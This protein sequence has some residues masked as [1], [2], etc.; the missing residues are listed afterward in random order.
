MP[1]KREINLADFGVNGVEKRGRSRGENSS[2]TLTIWSVGGIVLA[3]CGTEDHGANLFG[4][5]PES[6]IPGAD[7]AHTGE[8]SIR[9]TD[10]PVKGA[11]I[12]LD[13]DLGGQL[14]GVT[15]ENGEVVIESH[16]HVGA[17]LV[18]DVNGAVDVN[19][20]KVLTGSFRAL[21]G[22]TAYSDGKV[23]LSPL[24]NLLA[25]SGNPQGDL[26]SIFGEGVITVGDVRNYLN[27]DLDSDLLTP[28]L[29]SR[30]SLALTELERAEGNLDI[31]GYDATPETPY[32]IKLQN[33]FKTVREALVVNTDDDPTNDIPTFNRI[34]ELHNNIQ[35]SLHLHTQARLDAHTKIKDDGIPFAAAPND[36]NAVEVLVGGGDENHVVY[37]FADS[38]SMTVR[39]NNDLTITRTDSEAAERLFGFVDP[40]G[41][42]NEV[43]NPSS[44]VGIFIKP[45]AVAG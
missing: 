28:Q 18:A 16:Q 43:D 39:L 42:N 4:P 17:R 14:L 5:R 7:V 31:G 6:G 45:I 37:S 12:Y 36:G 20:G 26:D 8:W 27:Y 9:V 24:T 30:A 21:P 33:L 34:S 10:G 41:N 40:Y 13:G 35:G 44:L 19:T 11:R 1:K 32:L 2:L 29:I 23:L 3:A 15:D 22:D 25:D 38:I